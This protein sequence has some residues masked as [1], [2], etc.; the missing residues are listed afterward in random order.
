[1]SLVL[2]AGLLSSV[3]VSPN[4]VPWSTTS[5]RMRTISGFLPTTVRPGVPGGVWR[6][7]ASSVGAAWPLR[8]APGAA[9]PRAAPLVQ[10]RRTSL[11]RTEETRWEAKGFKRKE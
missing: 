5:L 1:M 7:R 3:S 4:W 10:R 6:R 2:T 8:L 9:S 11:N